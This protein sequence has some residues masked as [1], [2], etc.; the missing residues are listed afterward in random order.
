MIYL[1]IFA[2]ETLMFVNTGPCMAI[3]ANVV[4]PNLR[5]AALA[6]SYAAVHFLGDIWSPWLIGKAAD[7]FGDPETMNSSI[8]RALKSIGAVPTQVPGHPPENLVAGLLI[9]IP[10]LLLS[11]IVFLA[12]ARHLPREMALMRAKLKAAPTEGRIE[13]RIR[14]IGP[15][16]H[17]R[18]PR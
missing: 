9:L 4:Q 16:L 12:G 10:A 1:S 14:A 7:M 17:I 2:A 5:G 15:L 13:R 11:G 18:R 3:I 6:I 8:G